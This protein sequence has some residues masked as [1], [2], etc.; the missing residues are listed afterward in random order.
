MAYSR[1]C[2]LAEIFPGDVLSSLATLSKKDHDVCIWAPMP[3]RF[4]CM[5]NGTMAREQSPRV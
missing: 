2:S 4:S 3:G 1:F 5:G